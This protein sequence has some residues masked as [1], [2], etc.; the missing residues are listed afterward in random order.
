MGDIF[1]GMIDIYFVWRLIGGKFY[2][3]DVSNVLRMMLFNFEILLWDD[4]LFECFKI[5]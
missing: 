3:I 4:E 1:F 5:F 2:V